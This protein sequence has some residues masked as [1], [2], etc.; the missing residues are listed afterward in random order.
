MTDDRM[1]QYNLEAEESVLGS[2]LLDAEAIHIVKHT[3]L[4]GDF[5][6]DKNQWVWDACLDLMQRKEPVNQILVA[7]ELAKHDRLEAIGGSSYL[8]NLVY[9]VPTSRHVEYYAGIVKLLSVQ[10]QLVDKAEKIIDIGYSPATSIDGMLDQADLHLKSLRQQSEDTGFISI[11]DVICGMEVVQELDDL[12]EKKGVLGMQTGFTMIDRYLGGLEKGVQT[13]VCARS[14][15]G[16]TRF[17]CQVVENMA[18]AGYKCGFFSLEMAKSAIC[19]RMVYAWTD[20]DRFALR[21]DLHKGVIGLEEYEKEYKSQLY[22]AYLDIQSLPIKFGKL[23][24]ITL[25]G[26]RASL[27][28]VLNTQEMDVVFIDHMRLI[29]EP[30]KS[31]FERISRISWELKEIAAEFNVHMFTLAQMNLESEKRGKGQHRMKSTDI[32]G[33]GEIWENAESIISLFRPSEYGEDYTGNPEL[34]QAFESEY[35]R[36]M[37][38]VMEVGFPKVREGKTGNDTLLHYHSSGKIENWR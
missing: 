7:H 36:T 37:E 8:S 5:Y 9:N 20:I 18:Q 6:R 14:G 10:R 23:S 32:R 15:M 3:L 16:K 19:R 28:K 31:E 21:S 24:R 26:I 11:E 35:G 34:Q 30:A 22:D 33:S 12:Y 13:V 38:Q 27:L 29:N 2:I 1:P 25:N 17:A 4:D